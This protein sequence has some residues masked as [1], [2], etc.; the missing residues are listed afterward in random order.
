MVDDQSCVCSDGT[1][2]VGALAGGITGFS[3]NCKF[4]D[5][6][7]S[8]LIASNDEL[9]GGIIGQAINNTFVDGCLNTGM[10]VYMKTEEVNNSYYNKYKTMSGMTGVT[11]TYN[12]KEY[13]IR[14]VDDRKG[15]VSAYGGIVGYM[16]NCTI[17]RC[18]NLGTLTTEH[19]CGG[20]V[21]ISQSE[22][23]RDCLSDFH[24]TNN[25]VI[26]IAG[27]VWYDKTT[28]ANSLNISPFGYY[29]CN[30]GTCYADN[31]VDHPKE[32]EQKL[33]VACAKL[34]VNWQQNIGIDPYPTPTGNKGV[35]HTRKVTNQY[36]TVCLP[37]ALKSDDKI[38]YYTFSRKE[39][40]EQGIKLVFTYLDEVMPGYPV[41]FRAAEA[42]DAD[43][44]NPVEI[45]FNNAGKEITTTPTN[46]TLDAGFWDVWG[47]FEQ[48]VFEGD[49]AQ[50][51]YYVSGGEIRNAKKVT[52]APYRAWFY[53]P[54]IDDLKNS[55]TGQAKSIRFVIE[56]EDG[57]TTALE[58]VAND[59]MPVHINSKAYSLMGT[60]VNSSYR[61]IV[62]RNGKKMIQNR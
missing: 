33:G 18:A 55:V 56:D 6:I 19:S 59:L 52:I 42:K 39:D 54:S 26:G 43:A 47:T 11:K 17:S 12:G 29:C 61:G 22:T 23:I 51:I 25:G 32:D 3:D 27:Y 60:E 48:R 49:L 41:L 4:Y 15:D 2:L 57:S 34:G 30:D 50:N 9:V 5:C 13:L 1:Y 40:D 58:S 45:C 31:V 8:A 14:K 37:F 21:G 20:I 38:N 24:G 62:I 36:G 44:D 28:I 16:I 53:C 35:Y 46:K 7:N 10:L